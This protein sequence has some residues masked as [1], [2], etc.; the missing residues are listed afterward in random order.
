MPM[1]KEKK[2]EDSK[3]A[4]G[5]AA[6]GTATP[7]V[8]QDTGAV[9]SD[10]FGAMELADAQDIRE[11]MQAPQRGMRAAAIGLAFV[12]WTGNRFVAP[13]TLIAYNPDDPF[14]VSHVEEHIQK[15]TQK[16]EELGVP[17]SPVRLNNENAGVILTKAGGASPKYLSK[18]FPPSS[19]HD[20]LFPSKAQGPRRP[21]HR[22]DA[23]DADG[24]Y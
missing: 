21:R 7:M 9:L 16:A 4:A 6:G 23:D 3:G 8:R 2:D 20:W 5:G 11:A 12:D 22:N 17:C 24:V 13:N 19:K 18:K 15:M 14:Q 1:P 10:L